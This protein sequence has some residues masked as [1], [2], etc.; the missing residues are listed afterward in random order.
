MQGQAFYPE[1]IVQQIKAFFSDVHD[2]TDFYYKVYLLN[3]LCRS[4]DGR[5]YLRVPEQS[6]PHCQASGSTDVWHRA[7]LP[8]GARKMPKKTGWP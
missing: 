8:S 3:G 2:M 6:C 7:K 5:G 1:G 4:C